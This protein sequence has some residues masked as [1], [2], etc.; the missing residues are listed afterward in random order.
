MGQPVLAGVVDGT[1][2]IG[3]A[4]ERSQ[5]APFAIAPTVTSIMTDRSALSRTPN[6][7]WTTFASPSRA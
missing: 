3:P 2:L 5:Q 7:H 1:S 6:R 4:A